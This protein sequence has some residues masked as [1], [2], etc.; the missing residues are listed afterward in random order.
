MFSLDLESE[1]YLS[2]NIMW[3]EKFHYES[4]LTRMKLLKNYCNSNVE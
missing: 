4:E 1:F 3:G 2:T